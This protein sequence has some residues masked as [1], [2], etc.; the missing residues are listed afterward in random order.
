MTSTTNRRLAAITMTAAACATAGF[1]GLGA[2][3]DYPAVLDEPTAAI[4]DAYREHQTAITA[5]F[6]VLV[7]GAALLAPIAVLLARL[8][9]EPS[10]RRWIAG[11][12]VA[13]AAVQVVGLSRWIWLVPGVSRDALD[14]SSAADAVRRFELAHTWLGQAVGETLGYA[15]TAA[16]TLV[17]V[18]ALG[19]LPRALR[20]IGTIA[21]VLVATGTLIP[22]GV[23]AASLTNFAGYLLWTVWLLAIAWV[24]GLPSHPPAA[25]PSADLHPGRGVRVVRLA[26]DPGRRAER[27]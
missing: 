25:L 20:V 5:W 6:A 2:A 13:A 9:P 18:R 19:D 17:T 16:F 21:A 4:L 15:L 3:F 7:I 12:G 26:S 24:L 1:I 23:A 11:L 14:D 22:L 27:R 10:H 8:T